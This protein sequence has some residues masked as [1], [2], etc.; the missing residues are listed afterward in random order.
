MGHMM[1][2]TGKKKKRKI[3]NDGFYWRERKK[4][5]KGEILRIIIL[6]SGQK[7]RMRK[8]MRQEERK[9]LRKKEIFSIIINK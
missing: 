9:R 1:N 2:F 6:I 4:G 7:R 3:E 5:Q 8:R